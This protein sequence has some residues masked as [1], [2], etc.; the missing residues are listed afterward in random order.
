[1]EAA[2][3][4]INLTNK[5]NYLGNKIIN[6]PASILASNKEFVKFFRGLSIQ[7][8]PVDSKGA[9]LEF[10][11][12]S[13]ISKLVLYFRNE[14]TGQGDSLRYNFVMN[15]SSA[16]Y[17][18]F[19]H[20]GYADASPEFQ[21][22]VV[23]KDTTLGREKLYVQ[24]GGGT[25]IKILMPYLKTFGSQGKVAINNAQLVMTSL[26][27]DT[28]FG[29]IPE[30]GLVLLDSAGKVGKVQDAADGA[31]YFGGNYI[32]EEKAYKFRL[33]QH[34]QNLIDKDTVENPY[35]YIYA[36]DPANRVLTT[37]RAIL[38]GTNPLSSGS[39]P[40]RLQLEVTYTRLQ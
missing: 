21:Q 4:R 10:T 13:S 26:D 15:S 17:N 5:T 31:S 25:R 14:T 9:L 19:D 8:M 1:M 11:T 33:T 20:N 2:Q 32:E 34:I 36:A 27:N 3:L 18:T 12:N 23:G 29:P 40:T 37:K 38:N 7:S 24:P 39:S 30:L 16:H 35:L 28:T 22:Q 6:A